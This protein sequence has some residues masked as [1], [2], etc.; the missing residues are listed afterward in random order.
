[1]PIASPATAPE[2]PIDISCAHVDNS[3]SAQNIVTA[4]HP[5]VF[6]GIVFVG[7]LE[8]GYPLLLHKSTVPTRLF[9]SRVVKELYVGPGHDSPKPRAA[10][11]GQQQHLTPPHGQVQCRHVS[12]E[13]NIL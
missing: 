7:T 13:S 11:L 12:R 5:G 4:L 2:M 6:W 1:M 10:T 3:T 8:L 9:F